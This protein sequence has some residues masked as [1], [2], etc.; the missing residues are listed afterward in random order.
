VKILFHKERC[1]FCQSCSLTA[2][3]P[4]Q[5]KKDLARMRVSQKFS[6]KLKFNYCNSRFRFCL[7]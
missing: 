2:Y 6:Q 3:P 4:F 1:L 7:L 5:K